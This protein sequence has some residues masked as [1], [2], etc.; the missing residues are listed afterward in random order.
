[1]ITEI[2]VG[3]A[4]WLASSPT[5]NKVAAKCFKALCLLGN[6]AVKSMPA[7]VSDIFSNTEQIAKT[8]ISE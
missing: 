8:I 5:G 2:I 7:G 4:V 3:S 6:Y 1:M